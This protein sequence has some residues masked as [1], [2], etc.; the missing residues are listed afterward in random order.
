[1]YNQKTPI[2]PLEGRSIPIV[3]LN[4]LI[5]N[6]YKSNTSKLAY[7]ISNRTGIGSRHS[8]VR[9]DFQRPNGQR[10]I[11][12]IPKINKVLVINIRS[13]IHNYME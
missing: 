4:H 8:I 2:V 5:S 13:T 9:L 3:Y 7:K 11:K 1:M 6:E 12:T 10:N